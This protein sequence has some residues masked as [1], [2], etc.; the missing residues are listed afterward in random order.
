V[1]A[2]TRRSSVRITVKPAGIIKRYVREQ[3][4][5]VPAG[6]TSAALIEQ[7]GIPCQLRMLSLVNGASRPLNA[8]L[9]DGDE[10]RLV[11]L[12]FGG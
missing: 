2:D 11:A 6:S 4:M 12:V 3:E 7:L 9:N 8:E 1:N 5:D 10:V